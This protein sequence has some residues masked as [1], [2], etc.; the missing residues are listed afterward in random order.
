M[1]VSGYAHSLAVLAGRAP[2]LS[3]HVSSKYVTEFMKRSTLAQI[4]VEFHH[5]V[6]LPVN[7]PLGIGSAKQSYSL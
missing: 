3:H 1:A 6:S 7:N 4:L 2:C 5:I